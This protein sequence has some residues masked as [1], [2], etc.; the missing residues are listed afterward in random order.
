[1]PDL[2]VTVY[3]GSW[4]VVGSHRR[5]YFTF[6]K[7]SFLLGPYPNSGVLSRILLPYFDDC[8]NLAAIEENRADG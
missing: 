2:S 3:C 8:L 5:V 7:D 1:V 6:G 4:T